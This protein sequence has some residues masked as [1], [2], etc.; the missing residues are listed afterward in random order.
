MDAN[1]IGFLIGSL[2]AFAVMAGI[3]YLFI[4]GGIK[5]LK[6]IADQKDAERVIKQIDDIATDWVKNYPA[7]PC[8]FYS[9]GFYQKQDGMILYL[10]LV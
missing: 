4:R 2:L 5:L 8:L 1:G 9:P 10:G 3:G 6:K 7:R